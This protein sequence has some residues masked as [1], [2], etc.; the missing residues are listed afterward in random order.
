M[1]SPRR[2]LVPPSE[3][4]GGT[5]LRYGNGAKKTEHGSLFKQIKGI[6]TKQRTL[7]KDEKNYN[8]EKQSYIEMKGERS[9]SV[10]LRSQLSL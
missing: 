5:P 4:E 2:L 8:G 9:P 6:N 1:W 7:E 10:D 3:Q